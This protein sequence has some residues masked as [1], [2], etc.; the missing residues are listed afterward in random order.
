MK[1]KFHTEKKS[2]KACKLS[3]CMRLQRMRPNMNLLSCSVLINPVLVNDPQ[4][5]VFVLGGLILFECI[6][7]AASADKDR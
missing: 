1:G 3:D 7:V 2:S 4:V 5:D 6:L